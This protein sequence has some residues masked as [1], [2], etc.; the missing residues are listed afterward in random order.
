MDWFNQDVVR[1]LLLFHDFR[2]L[3]NWVS[4]FF[5]EEH[6]AILLCSFAWFF[7][8]CVQVCEEG[9]ELVLYFQV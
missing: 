2:S 4:V 7:V 5:S 1:L 9:H 6:V 8:T 3:F